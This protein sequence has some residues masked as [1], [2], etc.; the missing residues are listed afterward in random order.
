MDSLKTSVTRK[1]CIDACTYWKLDVVDSLELDE[2]CRTQI[3]DVQ[4]VV[5][6][7]KAYA[8]I[9]DRIRE[10]KAMQVQQQADEA[11]RKQNMKR[12]IS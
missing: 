1:A 4:A 7:E 8:Q 10:R 6:I 2:P 3:N 11:K 9:V 12:V 5:R